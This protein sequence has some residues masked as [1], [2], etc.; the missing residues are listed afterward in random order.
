MARGVW[1]TKCYTSVVHSSFRHLAFSGTA[2]WS[3]SRVARSCV[4]EGLN[5]SKLR[6]PGLCFG[7][8]SLN[9]GLVVEGVLLLAFVVPVC[10]VTI[11]MKC[12]W[13]LVL[14]RALCY[15]HHPIHL[16]PRSSPCDLLNL[17]YR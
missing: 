6:N 15:A 4:Q 12:K 9:H 1:I 7:T 8:Q 10:P 5:T 14:P 3:I 13:R 16:P 17:G 2:L 11:K